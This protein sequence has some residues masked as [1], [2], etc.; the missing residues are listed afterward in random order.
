MSKRR[1]RRQAARAATSQTTAPTA[2]QVAKSITSTWPGVDG[3]WKTLT[4]LFGLQGAPGPASLNDAVRNSAFLLCS[5]IIAQDISKAK[6]RMFKK[7]G[8]DR[9]VEVKPTEHS[10]ARLLALDPNPHHTWMDVWDMVF[11]HF[12]I[13]QNAFMVKR[14]TTRGDIREIIP[15]VPGRVSL[16]VYEAG[17]IFYQVARSTMFEHML[18]RGFPDRLDEEDMIHVKGRLFDGIHGYSTL[19]AGAGA[20]SLASAVHAYQERLYSGGG[21][22]KVAFMLK[23]DKALTDEQF[24]RLRKQAKEVYNR[25]MDKDEPLLLE[26][27]SDVRTLTMTAKDSEIAIAVKNSITDICRLFRMPPHKVMH[28]DGIKYENM[29][30]AERMYV[31][32]SLVPIAMRFES[33]LERALLTESERLEYC[34]EFDRD[35]MAASDIKTRAEVVK[36]GINAGILTANEGRRELGYDKLQGDAGEVRSIPV[37]ITLVDQNND[38]VLEGVAGAPGQDPNT[39]P[40]NKPAAPPASPPK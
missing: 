28:F 6:L 13:T 2:D 38:P 22:N 33:A 30:S 11:R 35:M 26:N 37:N 8:D 20:I 27:G 4:D 16:L 24:Q 18:L 14:I 1:E 23:E 10:F 25:A 3:T 19:L 12:A 36:I 32:D 7:I 9:R 5:D 21:R 29:D 17:G 31:S 15:V 34:L 40:T 39:D